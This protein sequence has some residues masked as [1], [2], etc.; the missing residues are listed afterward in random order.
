METITVFLLLLLLAGISFFLG[1][2][3]SHAVVAGQGGVRALHS[4]P[5]H[6]GYMAALWALLP[7]L[8]VL[9]IWLGLESRIV[10]A[11]VVAELPA[12]IQAQPS[13]ELGLYY[14]QIVSYAR[15]S[16][17]PEQLSAAQLAG[18][19]HYRTLIAASGSMKALLVSPDR[20]VRRTAGS[21][22][23]RAGYAC[24]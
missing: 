10:N 11:M 2:K 18:T 14:N 13:S 23:N 17:G 20:G 22:A 1:R 3:R 19:E 8:L 4:L 15:G 9:V 12:D 21:A 7:A 6:Y 24:P 16:I 5:K